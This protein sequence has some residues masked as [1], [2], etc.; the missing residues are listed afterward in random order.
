[1]APIQQIDTLQA[2]VGPATG[3]EGFFTTYPLV[4]TAAWVVGIV[5][6][7]WLA[8]N[9][10]RRYILRLISRLVSQTKFTW[11]DVIFE[12]KVFRRLAHVAPAIVF[13]Y[14]APLVPGI[15]VSITQ[16]VQRV[17]MAYIVLVV[18]LS[19]DGLLTAVNDIYSTRP[20]AKSRPI[21][22]YLQIVKIV[23]FIAAGIVAV[24]TLMG[25]SP[26][27]ILGG[28]GAMTAVL[29]LVFKDTILSLVASVQ[30]TQYDMIA[31]GDW[32]EM[33]EYGADG[34]VIDIALHTI[35]VQNFDKTITTVPT[36]K[37]IEDSFKNWRG[38]SKSGGRRIKRSLHLDVHTVRFLTEEE[39]ARLGRFEV[40][41]NYIKEKKAE[42]EA[43][44]A[45]RMEAA[46]KTESGQEMIPNTRWFTN[47]GTFRAYVVNYLRQHPLVHQDMTLLV[48]QLQSGPTGL[49]MEIYVFSND[50]DWIRYEG[51]QSDIFD[52][53]LAMVPEFGLRI[54]QNPSGEDV[55]S[56]GRIL[57]GELAPP[58]Q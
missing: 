15:T 9:L 35:K 25:E 4:E 41:R 26:F 58:Q 51:F 32:I 23:L 3:L 33:P 50:T 57:N 29:L 6:L 56:V 10:T 8:D 24:S 44:N 39:V 43:H 45:K 22:G 34:D 31:V 20:D 42:V 11:D 27:L 52:H 36:H 21:K 53:L 28:F 14:G 40:L 7:A 47:V 2:P 18:V 1:M 49:P 48:R 38:M 12:R 16:L 54:F 30:I 46:G 19:V 17:A 5:L 37:F 55:R 13:Y